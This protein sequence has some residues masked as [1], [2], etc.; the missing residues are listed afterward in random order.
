MNATASLAGVA[1]EGLFTGD[2]APGESGVGGEVGAGD[3]TAGGGVTGAGV[4]GAVGVST[5]RFLGAG[6]CSG[7]WFLGFFCTFVLST[8]ANFASAALSWRVNRL[9]L[10]YSLLR[11]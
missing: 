10:L 9:I 3:G 11:S 7:S 6:S 4:A 2:G 5:R 1:I 8:F